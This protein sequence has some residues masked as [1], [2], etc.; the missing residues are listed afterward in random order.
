MFGLFKKK[1]HRAEIQKDFES[2]VRQ[3]RSVEPMRQALVGRGITLAQKSFEKQYTQAS[4]Q[5]APIAE[6]TAFID[7]IKQMEVAINKKDGPIAICSIGYGLF[8]RWLAAAAMSDVELLQQFETELDYFKTLAET[9]PNEKV[10][11]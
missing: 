5:A 9:L 8:N 3:I 2:M 1:D 4:F 6:R 7:H 10:G 11:S